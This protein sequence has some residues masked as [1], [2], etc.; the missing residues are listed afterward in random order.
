MNGANGRVGKAERWF[1]LMERNERVQCTKDLSKLTLCHDVQLQHG[2]VVH[3]AA[4]SNGKG[5]INAEQKEVYQR[6]NAKCCCSVDKY[7][8][9]QTEVINELS[10]SLSQLIDH[11]QKSQNR[12]PTGHTNTNM[13]MQTHTCI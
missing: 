13:W 12:S 5:R 4:H 1:T 10:L 8:L 7:L 9:D 2:L 3:L 6:S 11:L